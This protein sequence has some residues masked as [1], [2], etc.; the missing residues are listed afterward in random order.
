MNKVTIKLLDY[1]KVLTDKDLTIVTLKKT[2]KVIN[3][4]AH[5][6][7]AII[8]IIEGNDIL[9]KNL[10]KN[11]IVIVNNNSHAYIYS[12][13]TKEDAMNLKVRDKKLNKKLFKLSKTQNKITKIGATVEEVI[14]QHISEFDVHVEKL[15]LK[16]K[17]RKEGR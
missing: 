10:L 17:K 13:S 15:K 2:I 9:I 16:W 7:P 14:K 4:Q 5:V 8:L 11:V 6:Y 1:T 3:N 12:D